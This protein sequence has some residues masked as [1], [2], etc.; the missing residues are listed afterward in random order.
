MTS[1]AIINSSAPF[2]NSNG[3]DALDMALIFG[4]YEQTV[5][6]FFVGDGVWQLKDATKPE[7]LNVKNYLK[8]FNALA[9]YDVEEIYVCAKSLKERGLSSQLELA[10]AQIAQPEALQQ[11]LTEFKHV[12]RF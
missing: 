9:F 10:D 5:A 3:K 6:L 1:I 7:L 8:T 12:L 2:A 11:K 4:S